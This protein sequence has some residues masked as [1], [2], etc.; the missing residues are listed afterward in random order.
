M[1]GA[2]ALL[3]SQSIGVARNVNRA[4]IGSMT[5][6]QKAAAALIKQHGSLRKA[7]KASGINYAYLQ[8]LH[9]G[10]KVNPTPAMLAKLG[11][12]KRSTYRELANG[13]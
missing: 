11:L 6:L 5:K 12:E 2:Y 3:P 10:T 9:K 8:R 4:Y 13:R 7:G 1:E